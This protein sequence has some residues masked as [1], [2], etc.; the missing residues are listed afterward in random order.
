VKIK[1]KRLEE[2]L[3]IERMFNYA[4]GQ[5]R[6]DAIWEESLKQA[7]K[8]MNAE[9]KRK[10]DVTVT[11]DGITVKVKPDLGDCKMILEP[12]EENPEPTGVLR[13]KCIDTS[14]N[15][16]KT[17][18]DGLTIE[19][20]EKAKEPLTFDGL[21]FHPDINERNL[22]DKINPELVSIPCTYINPDPE[23]LVKELR[24]E[25]RELKAEIKAL[26]EQL[27][28]LNEDEQGYYARMVEA[29]KKLEE[30]KAE[31]E[32][33]KNDFE[34]LF[35]A[36]IV[37]S[38]DIVIEELTAENANLKDTNESLREELKKCKKALNAA[39]GEIVELKNSNGFLKAEIKK[40]KRRN[41]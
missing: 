38:R 7:E 34:R 4:Y 24:E 23:H 20:E 15:W 12:S 13:F 37:R 11:E 28:E 26:N 33:K 5:K 17:L 8:E 22:Y 21:R 18:C 6:V 36:S 19:A 9:P 2:L 10:V 25:A 40:L 31:K 16:L 39:S 35:G 3:R 29:E 41:P 32:A 30:L 1:R 27:E 14:E